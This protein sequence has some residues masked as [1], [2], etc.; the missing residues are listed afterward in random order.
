RV[1]DALA[2][3][4]GPAIRAQGDKLNMKSGDGGSAVEWHQDFA[5][6]PHS[7]DDLC[8][9]SI[10]LG[11][12]RRDNGCMMVVPG[13]HKEPILDHHQDGV[14]VGA[15][16]PARDGLDLEAAV[17]LEMTAGSLAV[18]HA[19]TLHG[20]APNHSGRP[21]R[22]LLYQYAAVDA[23]PLAGVGDWDAFNRQI[24]RGELTYEFRLSAMAV[25]TRLPAAPRSGSGIYELQK[26]LQEKVFAAE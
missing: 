21:R 18:H 17:P 22:L 4:I 20:S 13:S 6:Y 9:V 8:A 25:R 19:R 15:V 24:L 12:A 16:S 2:P 5:H 14:F 26:T 3:L 11:D 7:N 1:L 23:W 10:A